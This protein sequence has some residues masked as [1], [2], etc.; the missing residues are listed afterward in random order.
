MAT[1]TEPNSDIGKQS[2]TQNGIISPRLA[3]IPVAIGLGSGD[4]L[5]TF[6]G[7]YLVGLGWN[8]G[9]V[10]SHEKA[11]VEHGKDLL[12]LTICTAISSFFMNCRV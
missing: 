7:V 3:F 10:V 6:Q 5:S 1:A 11:I 12:E 4:G 9:S 8:E 2:W